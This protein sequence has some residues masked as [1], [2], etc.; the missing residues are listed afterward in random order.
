[1]LNFMQMMSIQFRLD[2]SRSVVASYRIVHNG[3]AL[4]CSGLQ[5]MFEKL[6]GTWLYLVAVT[7][8]MWLFRG[9]RTSLSFFAKIFLR[10]LRDSFT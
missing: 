6:S 2:E 10:L 7:A 4:V 5:T 3:I 9:L 1:M 8:S